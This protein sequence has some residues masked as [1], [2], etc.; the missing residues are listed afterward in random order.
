MKNVTQ[1]N[2]KK[3]KSKNYLNQEDPHKC[4]RS[5]EAATGGVL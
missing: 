4:V 2:V 5:I 3:I 1:K